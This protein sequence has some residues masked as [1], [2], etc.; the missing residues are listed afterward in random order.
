MSNSSIWPLDR[1][2]SNATTPGQSK[3]GSNGNEGVLHISQISKAGASSSESLMSHPGHL[4]D[5]YPS[6]KM[7]SMCYAAPADWA[8]VLIVRELFKRV[9]VSMRFRCEE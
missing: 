1:A 2:L 6:A 5:W 7:Q 9:A 4:W 8:G 3:P